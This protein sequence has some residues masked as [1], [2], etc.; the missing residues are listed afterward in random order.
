MYRNLC[1]W[2]LTV[3]AFFI[4]QVYG[5][6][7]QLEINGRILAADKTPINNALLIAG[8]NQNVFYTNE[9]GVFSINL[10]E[11]PKNILIKAQGFE[12]ILFSL[13]YNFNEFLE[14]IMSAVLPQT[15]DADSII[16]KAIAQRR[17]NEIQTQAYK[18]SFYKKNKAFIKK[19]PFQLP[20]ISGLYVPSK[21]DTGL[22]YTSERASN[23]SY[24]DRYHYKEEIFAQQ[25][26]GFLSVKDWNNISDFHL[27]LYQNK[28]FF[29]NI[30]SRGY[31]SPIGSSALSN[32]NYTP[33]GIYYEG[34]RKVY[35]IAF[36]PQ[37]PYE[38]VFQGFLALYDSTYKVAYA[39]FNISPE[40]QMEFTDSIHVKQTFGYK[41]DKYTQLNQRL[42]YRVTLLNYVGLYEIDLYYNTFEYLNLD[43]VIIEKGPNKSREK[44]DVF[45]DQS[46]WDTIRA[47]PLVPKEY[48]LLNN[49][50]NNEQLKNLYPENELGL[51]A[52]YRW[53]T[54]RAFY[55][56]YYRRFKSYG[57]FVDP[58]YYALGFNTVEGPYLRYD[59][60]ITFYKK[61]SNIT[62]TPELRYG[63]SDNRL[64]YRLNI[65]WFY[66]FKEPNEFDFEVGRVYNQFNDDQPIL[67]S[68]NSFYSLF[69]GIN[70]LKLY[71]KDYVKVGHKWELFSGFDVTGSFEYAD[72]S[73]LQNTT[74]FTLTGNPE[75]Y[76]FNNPVY[77]P[78][79][80]SNG[81]AKHQALTGEVSVFYKFLQLYQ[82]INGR[83]TNIKVKT[84][85]LYL[86]YR[87]GFQ[88]TISNTNYDFL[89]GGM[90]FGFRV[91]NIGYSNFDLSGG[92]F[93]TTKSL[94]FVDFKHFNGVQTFFLQ[95][96]VNRSTR[97]KQFSTLPYY[98]F[99]S[100]D[101]HFELHYEHDFDGYLFS[102]SR[103]L[104]Y[105]NIHS[106]VGFNYLNNYEQDPFLEF[107][108]GIDNVFHA[109]RIEFAGG[110]ENFAK[111]SPTIRFGVDFDYL[112]Y[113]KNRVKF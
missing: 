36:S 110:I 95:P 79:I 2:V 9:A 8:E 13:E 27:N 113:R 26:G 104:R 77:P 60:P 24:K 81:F 88:T 90:S 91:G 63:F 41:N 56:K 53:K 39:D 106:F 93:L 29:R 96:I 11:Q 67:P 46:I 73:P 40:T 18:G 45:K 4:F 80:Y 57:I 97:I 55:R 86:N 94:P 42:D 19:V 51:F 15:F 48:E 105:S 111:F 7:Q 66:D 52:D 33:L 108:V 61:K 98:D 54:Y 85:Q 35:L 5:F 68:I 101:A 100:R 109:L 112:Y 59:L 84:P 70:Y 74:G 25:E 47:V 20:A 30:T 92:K 64:K 16:T 78:F 107:F 83:K 31:Y 22:V 69:L 75:N 12:P 21:S 76:T 28:I 72:R 3:A 87:K 71:Q 102:K 99:S 23:F 50:N 37:R 43:A 10:T 38:A 17:L 1:L 89:S 6:G 62:L 103:Y 58:F 49:Q 65:N 14:I 32:Y 44:I 82:I 34:K